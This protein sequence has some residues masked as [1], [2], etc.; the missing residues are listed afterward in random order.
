MDDETKLQKYCD[1]TSVSD[2]DL[3]QAT[4]YSKGMINHLRLG[5]RKPSLKCA[6]RIEIATNKKV[7]PH[8]WGIVL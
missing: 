8:D 3:A 6:L 7:G 4:G 5:N 2:E 1:E